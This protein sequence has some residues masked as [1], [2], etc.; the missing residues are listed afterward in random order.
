MDANMPKVDELKRLFKLRAIG[1]LSEGQ[2]RKE[3]AALL[4]DKA[5]KPKESN[6]SR[7]RNWAIVAILV[8]IWIAVTYMIQSDHEDAQTSIGTYHTGIS[9]PTSTG[10]AL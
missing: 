2:Y 10:V 1:A 8:A 7:G 5:E 6:G 3:L 4:S 9:F